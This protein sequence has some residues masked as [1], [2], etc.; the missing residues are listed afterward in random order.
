MKWNMGFLLSGLALSTLGGAQ[1][2]IAGGRLEL[3]LLLCLDGHSGPQRGS[4]VGPRG[5]HG[6]Q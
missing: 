1:A 4:G 2:T 3:P 5:R 6:R